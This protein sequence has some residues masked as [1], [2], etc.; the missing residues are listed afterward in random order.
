MA[1]SIM[2]VNSAALFPWPGDNYTGL[3]DFL[4]MQFLSEHFGLLAGKMNTLEVEMQTNLP[5]IIK[6]SFST[7][8]LS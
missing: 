4:F 7:P 3:T 8:R 1:G 6:P 2:P 5:M